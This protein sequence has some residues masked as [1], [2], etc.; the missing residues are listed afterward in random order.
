MVMR[1]EGRAEG[2]TRRAPS[3][4]QTAE[5]GR[6]T[7]GKRRDK[8]RTGV[9]KTPMADTSF[10]CTLP[11]ILFYSPHPPPSPASPIC[12]P[13][14]PPPSFTTSALSFLESCLGGGLL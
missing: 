6:T 11:Q 14:C 12:S 3:A 10:P 8:Q 7:K 2:R 13:S 9:T 1:N 5:A 4:S